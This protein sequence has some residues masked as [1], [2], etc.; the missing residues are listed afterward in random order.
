[1]KRCVFLLLVVFKITLAFAQDNIF[2]V[3]PLGLVRQKMEIK[4]EKILLNGEL[5]VGSHLAIYAFEYKNSNV[6]YNGFKFS[7]FVRFYFKCNAP[8][9]SFFQLKGTVGNFTSDVRYTSIHS[10]SADCINVHT[11][12]S[13]AGLEID[14]GRQWIIREKISFDFYLGVQLLTLPLPNEHEVGGR[15]YERSE[16]SMFLPGTSSWWFGGPG[17]L[18]NGS[19]SCGFAF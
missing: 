12:F 11:N 18:I 2:S 15:M 10:I 17:S 19:I 7:P 6:P 14:F 13:T 1:M 8:M 5:S 3:A 16:G 4:Y 9:G